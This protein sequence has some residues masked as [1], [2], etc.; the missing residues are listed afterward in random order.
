MHVPSDLGLA[1]GFQQL[2]DARSGRQRELL[3]ELAQEVL[4]VKE[5]RRLYLL[6]W[7]LPVVGQHA[8]NQVG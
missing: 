4:A 6:C 5:A 2:S 7:S 8:R 3:P 1:D